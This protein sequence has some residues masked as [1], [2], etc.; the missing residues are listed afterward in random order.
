MRRGQGALGQTTPWRKG[1]ERLEQ[2]KT[3]EVERDQSLQSLGGHLGRLDF[4]LKGG[5][6]HRSGGGVTLRGFY[7]LWRACYKLDVEWDEGCL[8]G[9]LQGLC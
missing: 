1:E 7:E 2:Q 3:S 9:N 8:G 4:I 6:S 5:R